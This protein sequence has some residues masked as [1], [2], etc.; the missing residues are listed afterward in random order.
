MILSELKIRQRWFFEVS[1]P[2]C[3]FCVC[4]CVCV[5]RLTQG[6][7]WQSIYA[8]RSTT[9]RNVA[10]SPFLMTHHQAKRR[11]KDE[12]DWRS[13]WLI[14]LQWVH[15]YKTSRKKESESCS[16]V[17]HTSVTHGCRKWGFFL[18]F[19][20]TLGMPP[21]TRGYSCGMILRLKVESSSHFSSLI[22][23]SKYVTI[24]TRDY[25]DKFG[26][27]HFEKT[28]Q[29]MTPILNL[30]KIFCLRMLFSRH[31]LSDKKQPGYS[32]CTLPNWEL[33]RLFAFGKL[34]SQK[35]CGNRSTT[36]AFCAK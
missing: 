26:C 25:F 8:L 5:Y 17:G 32:F 19:P 22:L 7:F 13:S 1:S 27:C 2:T 12:T 29:M 36:R 20:T 15:R 3:S 34:I 24:F 4:V 31:T 30:Q 10:K 21:G 9:A 6:K 14:I 33:F 11:T 18:V 16:F 23:F 35:R 28:P